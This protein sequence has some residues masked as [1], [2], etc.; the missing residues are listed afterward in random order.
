MISAELATADP[1]LPGPKGRRRKD[2]SPVTADRGVNEEEQGRP[3]PRSSL[4][5]GVPQC[6]AP[7]PLA[8]LSSEKEREDKN[9][10]GDAEP[11]NPGEPLSSEEIASVPQTAE[12]FA[13]R[14]S[15]QSTLSHP[16]TG[17]WF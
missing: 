17:H 9:E 1:D 12:L 15:V 2:G 13:G 8:T 4:V 10:T 3:G 16:E 14:P 7:S 6:V 5:M 11:A